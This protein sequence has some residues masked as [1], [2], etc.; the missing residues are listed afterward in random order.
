MTI[1]KID[2]KNSKQK[3]TP[4]GLLGNILL[5]LATASLIIAIHQSITVGFEK[6]YGIF[7]ISFVFLLW[8]IYRKRKL[9][10]QNHHRSARK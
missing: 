9:A 2:K 10:K 7:M 8:N 3:H 1:K 4:Q 6:A 5:A